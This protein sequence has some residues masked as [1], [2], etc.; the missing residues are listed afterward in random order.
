MVLQREM[1]VPFWGWGELG[2]FVKVSAA[3]AS[4]QAKISKDSRWKRIQQNQY[5]SGS[6]LFITIHPKRVRPAYR[7]E[8]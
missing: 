6:V 7:L 1:P 4:E 2:A 8:M 3:G 5:L